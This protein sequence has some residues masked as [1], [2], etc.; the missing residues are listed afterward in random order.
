MA[1]EMAIWRMSDQG[2]IELGP[3][4]LK[5][6]SRLEAFCWLADRRAYRRLK[7][8]RKGSR[9]RLT[10]GHGQG[11]RI[12][13]ERMDLPPETAEQVPPARTASSIPSL[14]A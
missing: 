8:C 3:S 6:K 5:L 10:I 12:T 4:R 9:D 11:R 13:M 7:I 2:P 1:M 14:A